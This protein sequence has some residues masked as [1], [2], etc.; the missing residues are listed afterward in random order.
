MITTSRRSLIAAAAVPIATVSVPAIAGE[1]DAEL[2]RLAAEVKSLWQ[3]Y[4]DAIDVMSATEHKVW[5]W[6]QRFPEPQDDAA[7]MAWQQRKETIEREVGYIEADAAARIAGAKTD[8]AIAA[9]AASPATSLRGLI[10]KARAVEPG[11]HCQC[12]KPAPNGHFSHRPTIQTGSTGVISAAHFCA[13]HPWP[14]PHDGDFR[15]L[16]Q[17]PTRNS[18]RT[19]AQAPAVNCRR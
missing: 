10:A 8:A 15:L 1:D 18:K 11:L 19:L 12:E 7:F 13:W 14:S 16:R 9:F 4:G 3:A 5:Q 6:E 17:V 2:L